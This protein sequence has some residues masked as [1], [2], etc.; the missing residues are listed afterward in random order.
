M[1][2]VTDDAVRYAC[3]PDVRARKTASALSTMRRK[4]KLGAYRHHDLSICPKCHQMKSRHGRVCRKCATGQ[5]ATHFAWRLVFAREPDGA[6]AWFVYEDG[7]TN[8]LQSGISDNWDDA[9]LSAVLNLYPPGS[10]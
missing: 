7:T 10:T 3:Y 1:L 8:I 6:V 9:R 4:R 2:G 5:T